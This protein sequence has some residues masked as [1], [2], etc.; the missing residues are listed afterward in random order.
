MASFELPKRFWDK[1]YKNKDTSCWEWTAYKNKWGYG[2]FE[3]K[4][5]KVRVH[6]LI[7][8]SQGY[9]IEGL[10]IRHTCDNPKC[11]NP[12]HLL[13][14]SH[15]D[16]IRDRDQRKRGRW[17]GMKGSK[18]PQAKHKEDEIREIR[19]KHLLLPRYESGKIQNGK[20]R[21]LAQ[22][23][24]LPYGTLRNIVDNYQ[25]KHVKEVQIGRI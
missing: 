13:M 21:E 20:L 2:E 17:F 23:L 4:G 24:N 7:M 6:R 19:K 11:I 3:F 5:R 9:K 8:S 1:V 16:N 15:A 10:I 22:S 14:G 25:W 12:F 18:H